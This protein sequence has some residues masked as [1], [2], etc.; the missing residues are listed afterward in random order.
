MENKD[1]FGVK[2]GLKAQPSGVVVP[3]AIAERM[4][5]DAGQ[6]DHE[7]AVVNDN[8]QLWQQPNARLRLTVGDLRTVRALLNGGGDERAAF[9]AWF[10]KRHSYVSETD[11][12]QLSAAFEPF[13][14]WQ[15]RA[16]MHR[17]DDMP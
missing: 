6:Y 8:V 15:A 13:K 9:D 3:R 17:K 1:D 14:A 12:T 2:N 10:C 5:T 11:T 4:A 16:A 7:H